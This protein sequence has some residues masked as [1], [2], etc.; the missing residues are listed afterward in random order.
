V[1]T[2]FFPGESRK[3][4]DTLQLLV[5]SAGALLFSGQLHQLGL[6]LSRRRVGALSLRARTLNLMK[7]LSTVAFGFTLGADQSWSLVLVAAANA[8]LT[9]LVVIVGC[10]ISKGA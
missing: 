2:M 8:T 1:V 5:V 9:A 3:F 7:D 4:I 6:L 10:R